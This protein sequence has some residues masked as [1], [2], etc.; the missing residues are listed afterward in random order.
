MG[1]KRIDVRHLSRQT[2]GSTIASTFAEHVAPVLQD[3]VDPN[4][5]Q[6]SGVVKG[7]AVPYYLI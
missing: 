1:N 2:V 6:E 4:T 5:P 7:N 3:M